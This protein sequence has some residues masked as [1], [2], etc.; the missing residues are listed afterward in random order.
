MKNIKYQGV[1][2]DFNGC[3][4]ADCTENRRATNFI[5]NLSLTKRGNF[6]IPRRVFFS[7][8]CLF[9]VR[10]LNLMKFQALFNISMSLCAC[11]NYLLGLWNNPLGQ[12]HVSWHEW[13]C[14]NRQLCGLATNSLAL[15]YIPYLC[16][17]PFLCIICLMYDVM[18]VTRFHHRQVIMAKIYFTVKGCMKFCERAATKN[19]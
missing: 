19:V 1:S 17:V 11:L 13:A 5:S 8:D 9:Q 3:T 14:Y 16:I 7:F 12:Q 15:T 2:D 6:R 10:L 4:W 18:W